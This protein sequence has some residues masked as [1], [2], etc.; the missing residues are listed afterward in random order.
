MF[1]TNPDRETPTRI[2]AITKCGSEVFESLEGARRRCAVTVGC[3]F[4][5]ML[6]DNG[7]RRW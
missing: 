5:S 7:F 1:D 3:M 2:T 4:A 6:I